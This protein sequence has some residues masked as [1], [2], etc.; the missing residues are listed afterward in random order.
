MYELIMYECQCRQQAL[1]YRPLPSCQRYNYVYNSKLSNANFRSY[2]QKYIPLQL[3]VMFLYCLCSCIVCFCIVG[4]FCFVFFYCFVCVYLFFLCFRFNFVSF[5]FLLLCL[6]I[7]I[8]RYVLFTSCQ[9]AL[10]GYPD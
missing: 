1:G 7:L 2:T 9:L 8:V 5:V 4:V 3:T 10:F 6:C